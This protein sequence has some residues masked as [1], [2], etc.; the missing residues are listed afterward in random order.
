MAW[1]RR[2]RE[3]PPPTPLDEVLSVSSLES[4]PW[5][6][7][8]IKELKLQGRLVKGWTPPLVF[9]SCCADGKVQVTRD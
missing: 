3:P 5:I 7:R 9:F 4:S 2:E 1:K 8:R 6:Q